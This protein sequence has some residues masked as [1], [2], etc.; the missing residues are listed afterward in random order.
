[1]RTALR[2]LREALASGNPERA[3][4]QFRSTVSVLDKAVAKGALHRNTAA[5]RKARAARIRDRSAG[6]SKVAA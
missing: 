2:H 3:S 4:N 6:R 1:M 5:R